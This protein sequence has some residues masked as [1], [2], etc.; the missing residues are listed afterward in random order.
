ML[1]E[2][3]DTSS[4]CIPTPFPNANKMHPIPNPIEDINNPNFPNKRLI[5]I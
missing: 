2:R 3:A 1:Y 5:V 4:M